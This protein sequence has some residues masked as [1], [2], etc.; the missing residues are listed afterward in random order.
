MAKNNNVKAIKKPKFSFDKTKFYSIEEAVKL[1]KQSSQTKFVSSIDVAIKLNLDTSKADQQLRG[2]LALPHF[3]GKKKRILVLDVGLTDKDA[4]KLGVDFAG[5]KEKIE[6]ISK[7]WLDFDLIITTPKIMPQLSKL[8]K[9]LGTRGLMPNPKIG[10]VTTNLEKTIAEFKKGVNQYRTDSYGNVHMTIGKANA[11]DS[12]IIENIN[13]L[14]DFL[15]S[16][17]P[18]SVKGIY[19][20]NV[21]ISSTMGPGIKILINKASSDKKI[22]TGSKKVKV[23]TST[24]KESKPIYYKPVYVYQKKKVESKNPSTPP[25][26]NY[27]NT[28]KKEKPVVKNNKKT[29]SVKKPVANKPVLNNKVNSKVVKKPVNKKPVVTKNDNKIKPISKATSKPVVNKKPV[30]VKSNTSKP[31]VVSKSTSKPTAKKE[32]VNKKPVAVKSNTSKPKAVAKPVPKQVAKKEA[33]NNKVASS[34]LGSNT[35]AKKVVNKTN[36][37]PTSK[38]VKP[39]QKKGK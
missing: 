30:A 37:K 19:I 34:K 11:D 35:N 29:N 32:V 7:G 33:N 38:S 15:N 10:N 22:K 4:S 26:V 6:E 14:L 21:S 23:A 16:K 17:R 13:F 20:Q 1:A 18:A 5:E 9:I 36:V 3:F 8:G 12:K 27:T 31:K 28:T 39:T 2:T 24:E 25:K